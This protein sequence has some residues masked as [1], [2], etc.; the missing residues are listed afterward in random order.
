[1]TTMNGDRRR[2]GMWLILSRGTCMT[3]LQAMQGAWGGH[4]APADNRL[5]FMLHNEV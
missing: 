3:G 5:W 4:A 2:E 1:M